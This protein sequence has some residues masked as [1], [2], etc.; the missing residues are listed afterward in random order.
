MLDLNEKKILVTGGAGFLGGYIVEALEKLGAEVFSTDVVASEKT[1]ALDIT[2]RE[3][4]KVFAD[5]FISNQGYLD[6]LVN[7]AAVS[8]KGML[9]EEEFDNTMKVNLRGTDNC[10]R[11]LAPIMSP[12]SSIVNVSSVYGV[13]SPDFSIYDGN[14]SL[15]N[16]CAY[17]AS[18]AGIIQM[19]KYYAV[20][21]G[22]SLRVNAISPGGIFQNHDPSFAVPYSDRVPMGRMAEPQEIAQS[23]VFLLS[24]MSSYITGHNL[25]VDG[26]LSAW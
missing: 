14:E 10:I 16:S 26:G 6:G 17:G 18:K 11:E 22:S 7:N 1:M 25:V 24:E 12:G 19:T 2:T 4:V 15:Y 5:Q 20:K 9:T 8:F 3:R 21:F 23:I 13:L